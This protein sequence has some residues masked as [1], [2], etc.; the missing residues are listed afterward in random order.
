MLA[1]RDGDKTLAARE[2]T[3][4]RRRRDP[5]G[6][7]LL[8]RRRRWREEL[9]FLARPL[10]G[11]ENLANN[12][13]HPPV[14]GDRRQ[15]GAFSM[16]KASRAGSSNSSGGLR[17]TIT[18]VQVVS[19]LRTSE[20]KIYRQ[21]ISDP[22]ELADGFPV[23][24][25][26]LFGYAGIIIG[27]VDAGYFTPLQQELLREYVDRR[28]GGMLFLGGRFSL[29]RWR[30]GRF[31]PERTCCPPFCPRAG[32]T[33]IAIRQRWSLTAAGRGLADHA[34]PRRS[35]KERRALEEADLSGGLRGRRHAQAR[36]RRCWPDERRRAQAAVAHHAELRPRTHRGD[37]DRRGRGGGR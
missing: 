1:V 22:K 27:S 28:G 34:S 6:N 16:S 30:L 13:S 3:L 7:A 21:G 5:G 37:G 26:D 8:S 20:N 10:A 11:E 15:S 32:T 36:R 35:G 24:P 12:V 23:R 19:M 18:I 4:G 17:T 33:S 9:A 29:E 14:A 2:V 25:E 31:E